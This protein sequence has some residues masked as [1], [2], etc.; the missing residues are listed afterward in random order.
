MKKKFLSILLALS[1]LIPSLSPLAAIAEEGTAEAAP[2]VEAENG[3]VVS[4]ATPAVSEI[5][6]IE[7]IQSETLTT[8]NLPFAMTETDAASEG[9]IGRVKDAEHDLHSVVFENADGGLTLFYYNDPVKYVDENGVVRD[10][11]NKLQAR[12]GGGFETVAGDIQTAFPKQLKDGITMQKGAWQLGL[13]PAEN[14]TAIGTL[15]SDRTTVTYARDA[16]TRYEY[17]LTSMGFKEDIVVNRYTGQ[18]RYSFVL[19][20][21]G[22]TPV[23]DNGTW[24]LVDSDGIHRATL[25][26]IVV[27]TADER[28]NTFGELQVQQITAGQEYRLTILLDA[29]WLADE[30]TVYPITIDPA[31]SYTNNTANIQDITVCQGTTYSASSGSLYVGRN[32]SGNIRRALMRFPNLNILGYNITSATVSVRDIMCESWALPMQCYQY[33]GADWSDSNP[34]TWANMGDTPVGIYLSGHSVCYVNG[35]NPDYCATAHR[36][37]Y[38]ITKLAQMWADG[39]ASPSDGVVFRATG[40][41]E[42]GTTNTYKT[43]ASINR[44]ASY[45]PQIEINYTPKLTITSPS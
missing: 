27:F 32:S 8:D 16:V 21:Y 39:T 33:T 6:P 13:A 40:Y 7:P 41:Y 42:E 29:D 25:G 23:N 24:L 5:E 37:V 1:L 44:S 4:E 26:E 9:L 10:K 18:T 30:N 22:L 34:M 36:Y 19:K 14:F 31:L 17:N 11:S 28:N 15:S 35:K 38:N 45:Y 43:F 3:E 20:T 12:T 2:T